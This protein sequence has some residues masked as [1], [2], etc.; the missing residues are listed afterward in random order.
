MAMEE[1]PYKRAVLASAY[2]PVRDMEDLYV[3]DILMT[4][5]GL[6]NRYMGDYYQ[7]T[8]KWTEARAAWW[9]M[10][11]KIGKGLAP[12]KAVKGFCKAVD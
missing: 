8:P 11:Q 2:W 7:V 3:N 5:Y 10:L 4:E 6:F 9:K 12:S 1:E